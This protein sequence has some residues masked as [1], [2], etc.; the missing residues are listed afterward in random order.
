MAMSRNRYIDPA[1]RITY[2]LKG[3]DANRM[4]SSWTWEGSI[5][6]ERFRLSAAHQDDPPGT[7]GRVMVT[8]WQPYKKDAL[9]DANR[10]VQDVCVVVGAMVGGLY[11]EPDSPPISAEE[12]GG[13]KSQGG[14][15][16]SDSVSFALRQKLDGRDHLL[17]AVERVEDD[18]LVRADVDTF[19]IAT[20]QRNAASAT[21]H[22][23]RIYERH[24]QDILDKEA[25]LIA[26]KELRESAAEAL[27]AELGNELTADES[28]RVRQAVVN[29]LSRVR[30]RPR[31]DVLHE[32]VKALP[33]CENISR[34]LLSR[35][36]SRRGAVAHNPTVLDEEV[37][38]QEAES[39][40]AQIA[41]ALIKRELGIGHR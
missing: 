25:P 21:I 30:K 41:H 40:L 39:A 4:L 19:Q 37:S 22:R 16:V 24:A 13:A 32:Y 6:N 35:I 23:F 17:K 3:Y 12:L 33:G 1:W 8:S 10:A 9:L 11:V 38:D 5:E 26:R 14:I 31:L 2:T 28:A 20:S 34:Q 18:P 29:A 15:G 7:M 27:V 36:D